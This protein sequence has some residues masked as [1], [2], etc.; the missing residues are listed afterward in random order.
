M[1]NLSIAIRTLLKRP[2]Y[3]L[4]VLLTLALG[5]GA[6]T[7]MFTLLDA[8]I[9]KPLPFSNPERLVML[10]GV[11]GPERDIRGASFPEAADWRTMN[12]T[13]VD[14]SIY[15]EISLNMRLGNEALRIDGEMVSGSFFQLL[16]VDAAVGRTFLADEDRVPDA[17]PAAVISYKLWKERFGGDYAAVGR[18]VVLNNRTF[19]IVG[20]MPERFAGLSFDT[21]IWV[22]SMM[23]SLTSGPSVMQSRGNRWL[24]AVARLKDGVSEAR[25]QDDMTRVAALLEKDHPD[26]NRQR[27]V[28]VI[29]VHQSML[30]T[31]GPLMISL[32]AAVLLFLLVA[33]AN[34]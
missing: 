4:S 10:R 28:Q 9:L 8:A 23:V 20:V 5:I 17:A 21:D 7:M 2:G 29:S 31:R 27:G 14:V 25:A 33:C 22:P 11:A 12:R 6:S 34:V 15:D 16:G 19:T 3:G 30:G 26:F 18:T 1:S 13:L 24:G 32:F